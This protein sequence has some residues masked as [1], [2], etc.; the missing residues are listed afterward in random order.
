MDKS[1]NSQKSELDPLFT[2]LV[3]EEKSCRN[4]NNHLAKSPFLPPIHFDSDIFQGS[5]LTAP[6]LRPGQYW[7]LLLLACSCCG[8]RK[9][10]I[11]LQLKPAL[12]SIHCAW[13]RGSLPILPSVYSSFPTVSLQKTSSHSHLSGGQV[14][15]TSSVQL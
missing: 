11:Q 7:L 2:S 5:D 13:Q 14:E 9:R 15:L 10:A 6:P 12:T 8:F 3:L 1:R 4:E